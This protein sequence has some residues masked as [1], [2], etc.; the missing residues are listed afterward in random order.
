VVAEHLAEHVRQFP[1][2]EVELVDI[3]SGDPVRRPV[4]LLFTTTHGNPINDKTW[5]RE[6]VKGGMPPAGRR[7]TARSMPCGNSSPPR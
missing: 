2:V 6:W 5:S 3:T 7:S 4:A 1:P